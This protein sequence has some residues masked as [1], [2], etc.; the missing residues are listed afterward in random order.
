[1]AGSRPVRGR[2]PFAN[3]VGVVL[4]I[5]CAAAA[6]IVSGGGAGGGEGI[7]WRSDGAGESW[8]RDVIGVIG[9]D[10]RYERLIY[11]MV[12]GEEE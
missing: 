8:A 3:I 12:I 4:Q 11:D 2:R 6:A 9:W 10:L 7:L 1:M 5:G